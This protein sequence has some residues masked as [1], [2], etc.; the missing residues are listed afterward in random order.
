MSLNHCQIQNITDLT[1]CGLYAVVVFDFSTVIT[2]Q[3]SISTV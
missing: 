1:L 3:Y 2:I